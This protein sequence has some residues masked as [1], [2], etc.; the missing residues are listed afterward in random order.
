MIKANRTKIENSSVTGIPVGY[1]VFGAGASND[2]D[3]KS[4]EGYTG[5]FVGYNDAGLLEGNKMEKADTIRGF[6]GQIGEFSGY[7]DTNTSYD[8]LED[9]TNIEKAN[10]YQV[11][12]TTDKRFTVV[13]KINTIISQ[14]GIPAEGSDP[15]GEV[16]YT[17]KHLDVVKTHNDWQDVYMTT[18][19][20]TSYVKVPIKVYVSAAQ[21]DLMYG[22]ETYISTGDE[23]AKPGEMQ[24]PCDKTVNITIQK[25]WKDNDGKNIQRPR[26]INVKCID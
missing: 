20:E 14:T 25:V 17:I 5:G 9:P 23:T 12:R 13:K 21:A 10:T 4:N 6:A 7:T 15:T 26:S 18:N 22:V 8:A 24:D 1:D 11:Y 3:G 2:K 19:T 16:T